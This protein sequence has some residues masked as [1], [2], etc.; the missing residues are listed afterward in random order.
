MAERWLFNNPPEGALLSLDEVVRVELG[1]RIIKIQCTPENLSNLVTHPNYRV[2]RPDASGKMI[3]GD[4]DYPGIKYGEDM[5]VVDWR[6]R[7]V[8]KVWKVY[9]WELRQMIPP[10][11]GWHKHAQYALF[12]DALDHA[13]TLRKEMTSDAVHN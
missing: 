6:E 1:A 2:G 13:R 3:A 5:F 7:F 4:Q 11:M 12:Q 8:P 9:R 10:Q